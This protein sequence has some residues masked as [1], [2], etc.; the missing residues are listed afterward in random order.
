MLIKELCKK[1]GRLHYIN[2]SIYNDNKNAFIRR[3]TDPY[4]Y[5]RSIQILYILKKQYL[6]YK[7]KV[8][9]NWYEKYL[10]NVKKNMNNLI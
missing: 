1:I 9:A 4:K 2:L 10:Y 5:H 6:Y 3:E 8:Y 7:R